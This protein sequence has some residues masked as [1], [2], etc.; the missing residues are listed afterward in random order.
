MKRDKII[1]QK[2]FKAE[3]IVRRLEGDVVPIPTLP[4][5]I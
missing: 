1:R 5:V 4:D 3:F 2:A